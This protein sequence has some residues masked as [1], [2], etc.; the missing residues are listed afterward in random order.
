M[1]AGP[2]KVPAVTDADPLAYVPTCELAAAAI[3]FPNGGGGGGCTAAPYPA[4]P[5][6]EYADVKGAPGGGGGGLLTA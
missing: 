1:K 6:L 2:V 5:I 3:A 4:A